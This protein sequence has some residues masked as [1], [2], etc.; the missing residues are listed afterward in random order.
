ML[1]EFVAGQTPKAR[2]FRSATPRWDED[3]FRAFLLD[4]PYLFPEPLDHE[5]VR[6]ELIAM[7]PG[8][9]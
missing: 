9:R 7:I 3:A 2:L 5:A 8:G 6:R 4:L 1:T